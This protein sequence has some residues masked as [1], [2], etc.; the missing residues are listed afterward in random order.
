VLAATT[1]TAA[2]A[3]RMRRCFGRGLGRDLGRHLAGDAELIRLPALLA[4]DRDRF[5]EPLLERIEVVALLARQDLGNA[6]RGLE[7]D[8]VVVDGH[9]AAPDLAQN[10][11]CDGLDALHD[12][13]AFAGRARL[14]E[15]L[16]ERL[17][18]ALARH[19]D[20]AELA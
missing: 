8:L 16:D 4:D 15:Q 13:R 12:A 19:L 7:L 14:G 5:L 3:M 1:T 2:A 6:R 9:A 20:E 18:R 10:F 17:A 11:I